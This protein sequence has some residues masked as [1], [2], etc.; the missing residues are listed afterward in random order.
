[1]RQ[2]VSQLRLRSTEISDL[3]GGGRNLLARRHDT[4]LLA[5][6]LFVP[7][8]EGSVLLDWSTEIETIVVVLQLRL[9]LAGFV[10]KEISGIQFIVTEKL[11]ARAVKL[12]AAALRDEIDYGPLRLA[13]FSTEAITLYTELL[14]GIDGR[15]N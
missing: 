3:L 5:T 15:K 4:S 7:E 13:I 2:G 12:V 6:P 1:M 14:N 11:K 8:K 9:W 10:E